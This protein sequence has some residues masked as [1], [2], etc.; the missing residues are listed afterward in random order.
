MR[1]EHVGVDVGEQTIHQFCHDFRQGRR[2]AGKGKEKAL[3]YQALHR[4]RTQEDAT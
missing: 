1:V 2:N 3:R 4:Q